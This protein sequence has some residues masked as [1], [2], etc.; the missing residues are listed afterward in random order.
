MAV[1]FAHFWQL[2]CTIGEV[3]WFWMP[4]AYTWVTASGVGLD[5]VPAEKV[6]Y[7]LSFE[8]HLTFDAESEQ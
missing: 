7:Q 4:K 1:K 2:F 3:L 5:L 8:P 6:N